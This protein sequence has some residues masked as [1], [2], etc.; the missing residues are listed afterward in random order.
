MPFDY[1]ESGY[2]KKKKNQSIL[3]VID[4]NT[5]HIIHMT[6][7][8]EHETR[9]ITSRH[10]RPMEA[11]CV[12][13]LRTKASSVCRAL[14]ILWISVHAEPLLTMNKIKSTFAQP[15]CFEYRLLQ[16]TI[17]SEDIMVAQI[18][19]YEVTTTCEQIRVC[20]TVRNKMFEQEHVHIQLPLLVF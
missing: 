4:P 10:N 20:L 5:L 11:K 15:E 16:T 6:Y 17:D 18:W 3:L 13:L 12:L 1:Y 9:V 7:T 19:K 2:H 8:E 14:L